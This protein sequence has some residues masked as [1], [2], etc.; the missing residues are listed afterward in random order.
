MKLIKPSEISAKIL[1]LMDESDERFVIVSPYMKISKWYK[2]INKINCLKSRD[3]IVEIYVREDPENEDTYRELDGLNLEYKKIPHLHCKF[4]MN[5][6]CGIVSS[7]NLLLSSEINSL[8]I[9]YAT[10]NRSEYIELLGI[11]QRFIEMGDPVQ[12]GSIVGRPA[13]DLKEVILSIREELRT[14]GKNAWPMLGKNALQLSTGSNHY[15]ISINGGYLRITC[16]L[17]YGSSKTRKKLSPGIAKKIGELT[18]LQIDI[19]PVRES[20]ILHISGKAPHSM[21]STC[22]EGI[23]EVDAGYIVKSVIRFINAIEDLP[24]EEQDTST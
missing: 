9:G 1:S 17:R 23:L 18:A 3:I 5:E 15:T 12:Y 14:N 21:K 16:W 8:E 6:K 24:F 4:Y 11:F 22:I 20:Y 2:L 13:A 19:H 10:V 7:M